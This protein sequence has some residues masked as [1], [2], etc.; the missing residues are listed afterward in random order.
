MYISDKLDWW[1]NEITDYY[2]QKN[3]TGEQIDKPID[4]NDHAMDTTKY[5]L[6]HRPSV[7][8]LIVA[9][10]PKSVGWRQWGERDVEEKRRDVRHG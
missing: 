3:P 7:S 4:K 1:I 8:K 6:S 10:E 5:M 9:K 2:W